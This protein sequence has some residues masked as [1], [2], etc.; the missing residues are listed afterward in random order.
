VKYTVNL[1]SDINSIQEQISGVEVKVKI[2]VEVKVKVE[3]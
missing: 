3:A 2:K 1:V